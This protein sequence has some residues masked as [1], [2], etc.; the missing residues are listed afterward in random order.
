M[1]DPTLPTDSLDM[2]SAL[3]GDLMRPSTL[4]SSLAQRISTDIREPVV[5]SQSF[6]RFS[7]D[8]KGFLSH[9]SKIA[10]SVI[11]AVANSFAYFPVSVGVNSLISRCV[12]KVGNRTIAETQEFGALQGYRSLFE[13]GE[14][15]VEREQF[16]TQRMINHIPNYD[17]TAGGGEFLHSQTN[18]ASYGL[19]SGIDER[20]AT[21]I[22][23]DWEAPKYLR[24]D[25]NYPAESPVYS[26]FLGDLFDIFANQDLPLFMLDDEVHIELHFTPPKQKRCCL[27]VAAPAQTADQDYL[28]DQSETRMIYD[29]IYY[30]GDAMEAFRAKADRDGGLT[31]NYLD[32]RLTRRT[33]STAGAF[34][35]L[36]QAIGG[37]GRFVDKIIVRIANDDK[38]AERSLLNSYECQA[39]KAG[40]ERAINL[41]YNDRFEFPIDRSNSS[42][43]FSTMREAEGDVPFITRAEYGTEMTGAITENT[44]HGHVQKANLASKFNYLCLRP[45]REER[46]NN[47]GMDLIYKCPMATESLTLLVWIGLRKVATLKDGHFDCYF[48]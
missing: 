13:T 14:E 48:A 2:D 22:P 47:Q 10:F 23:A 11:P 24:L 15:N 30:S 5:F 9:Q 32:Y 41:R 18:S 31:F 8:R 12:L 20:A 36:T 46:V 43:L 38:D 28:I 7:L 3:V 39:P 42:L 17:V 37:A 16:L 6:C 33:A 45:S 34:D 26:I 40:E 29:T 25:G 19:Y 4:D 44:Y 35:N 1:T 21:S 27:A